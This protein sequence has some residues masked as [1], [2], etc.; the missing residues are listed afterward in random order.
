ME[1]FAIAGIT[2]IEELR[3]LISDTLLPVQRDS[4]ARRHGKLCFSQIS[5][6]ILVGGLF[7]GVYYA[8]GSILL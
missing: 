4:M 5:K 1:C 2:E 3:H 6:N 7:W 8:I